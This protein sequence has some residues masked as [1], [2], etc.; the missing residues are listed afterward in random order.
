MLLEKNIFVFLNL[1]T[2]PK[3]YLVTHPP[4]AMWEESS[5]L[6]AQPV[7]CCLAEGRSGG[8]GVGW[9]VDSACKFL[10]LHPNSCFLVLFVV[11]VPKLLWNLLGRLNFLISLL[12]VGV[13]PG[14]YYR[15]FPNHNK[16]SGVALLFH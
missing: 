12:F 10:L 2:H 11:V 3:E 14:Q 16:G 7:Q 8:V 15:F 5:S 6:K 13:S 1:V 4:F 9:G